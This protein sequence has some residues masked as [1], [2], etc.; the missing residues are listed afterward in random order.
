ML[1]VI[2]VVPSP[3]TVATALSNSL[4]F[5]ASAMTSPMLL[6][7]EFPLFSAIHVNLASNLQNFQLKPMLAFRLQLQSEIGKL[8]A[9]ESLTVCKIV[10]FPNFVH[11]LSSTVKNR[12]EIFTSPAR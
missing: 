8:A 3:A 10:K 4:F 12:I 11:C 6:S 9:V 5:T 1:D 2:T 7:R